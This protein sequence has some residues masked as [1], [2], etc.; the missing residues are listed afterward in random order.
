MRTPSRKRTWTPAR[1]RTSCRELGWA[2]VRLCRSATAVQPPK[3]FRPHHHRHHHHY[4]H[5][6]CPGPRPVSSL[7]SPRAPPPSSAGWPSSWKRGPVK[8]RFRASL[9]T[10]R[11]VRLPVALW[12][13]TNPATCNNNQRRLTH[14][15]HDSSPSSW[16][17]SLLSRKSRV[18]IA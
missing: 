1:K 16:P 18:F 7:T 8:C 5:Q 9:A 13:A 14:F 11:C 2:R 4:H 15:I 6:H 12:G 10:I 17:S 3:H